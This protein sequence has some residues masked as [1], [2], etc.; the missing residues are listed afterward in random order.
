MDHHKPSCYYSPTP[1][2]TRIEQHLF[3]LN[4]A[5]LRIERSRQILA[6]ESAEPVTDLILKSQLAV[7]GLALQCNPE[8]DEVSA[9]LAR[10]Y[11]YC[12]HCLAGL[13]PERLAGAS[14]TLMTLRSGFEEVKGKAIAFE[15]S[16]QEPVS[17]PESLLRI[18]A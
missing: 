15:H 14:H 11:E 18:D 8:Q 5:I 10:L 13:D 9:N 16:S 7:T 6:A 17:G 2:H 4:E 1:G 12:L 3:L